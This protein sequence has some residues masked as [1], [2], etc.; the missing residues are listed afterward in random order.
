MKKLRV[1]VN[2]VSYDVEVEILE[3]DEEGG[4]PYGFPPATGV[5]ASRP[6]SAAAPPSQVRSVS[7]SSSSS[8]P[9]TP[10]GSKDVTSP[11]AGVVAEV[12]VSVGTQVAENDLLLIIE[13]MKMHTNISSP[14]AGKIKEIKIKTGDAVQQGQ[15]LITFE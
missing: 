15:T 4:A 3:D 9:T 1:T 12:K 6:T 7:S 14:S 2:G 10:P 8:S 13:A 11:I 5:T